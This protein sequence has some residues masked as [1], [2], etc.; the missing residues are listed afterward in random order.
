MQSDGHAIYLKFDDGFLPY[1]RACLN[2]LRV[3]FPAHP[4]IL[5]DYHGDD[6]DMYRLL[7]AMSVELLPPERPP[8][9][10]QHVRLARVGDAI[11]DRFRLF[12]SGLNQYQTILHLDADVLVLRPLDDLFDRPA[13][14]F[15][16]NHEPD[17]AVRI[18]LPAALPQLR[19]LLREDGLPVPDGP[20]DMANGGLFTL[21][22]AVRT[23]QTLAHLARLAA[24][25]GKWFA[26]A[27]QS[28]LS[29]WLLARGERPTLD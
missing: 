11:S 25:Y 14:F 3:N 2:S 21:P 1:A 6:S 10:M 24:R 5:A 9:F 20:D 7:A 19:A 17:P 8:A 23:P 27:D 29:L 18:F 28:L 4:Q 26:Y 16:A 15:V 22:R 13:P 12:R